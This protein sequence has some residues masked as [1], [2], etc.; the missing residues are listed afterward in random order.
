[1]ADDDGLFLA[2]G[3]DQRDHVA[4]RVKDAVGAGI[5]RCAGPAEP[6]HVGRHDMEAGLGQGGDLMPPGIG[7]FGPAV[8]KYHQ[9]TL[10]LFEDEQLNPVGGKSA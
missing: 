6:S 3:G 2:E 8:A 7:Q 5:G 4:D 10:T 1:M 9:R